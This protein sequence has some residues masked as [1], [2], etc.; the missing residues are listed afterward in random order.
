MKILIVG[1]GGVEYALA[2]G[3]K[4]SNP[5]VK[6]FCVPGNVAMSEWCE[7]VSINPVD[8]KG[9]VNFSVREKIDLCVICPISALSA[10]LADMLLS[11]GIKVLGP[12][13]KSALIESSRS[14]A[15]N[16]M[17][18][19]RMQC[20]DFRVFEDCERAKEYIAALNPFPGKL[21]IR[22][23][24]LSWKSATAA[25]SS[26]EEAIAVVNRFMKE[27]AAGRD[28]E[29]IIIEENLEGVG[30]SFTALWDSNA[31][32]LLPVCEVFETLN[33]AGGVSGTFFW[34]ASA[35]YAWRESEYKNKMEQ[36]CKAAVNVLKAEAISYGGILRID[37]VVTGRGL[38]PCGFGA[39]FSGAAVQT[40]L[41]LIKNDILQLLLSV[42]DLKL[43]KEKIKLEN[44]FSVCVIM[45][46]CGY[47]DLACRTGKIISGL[48]TIGEDDAFVFYDCIDTSKGHWV[49]AGKEVFEIVGI[50]ATMEEARKKAYDTIGKIRYEGISFRKDIGESLTVSAV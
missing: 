29:R 34:G 11:A 9:I 50:G 42:A 20:P 15:L 8:L 32:L 26:K 13:K 3:I 17:K 44:R 30:I 41:P 43:E 46:S 22:P 19:H 12:S 5:G 40:L 31:V 36:L 47:P 4:K 1:S 21:I 2:L 38:R 6:L 35:P 37:A 10:G 16:F 39:A 25:A 18:K 27:G 28:G 7:R 14:F 24:G 48:E 33:P 23:D 45:T 49:T